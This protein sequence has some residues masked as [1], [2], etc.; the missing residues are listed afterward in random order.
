MSQGWAKRFYNSPAWLRNR[1]SYLNS[2]VDTSGH[3][4]NMSS[5][6]T[7]YYTD[8]YGIQV[9]VPSTSV[10]PPGMCER[11]FERGELVPA[12]VVHHIRHLTPENI[13][14]P[15]VT[16]AYDNFRRLCQDCHAFVHGGHDEPR[17]TFDESG[18][19]VPKGESL[20]DMVMRLT[21]TVDDRRNIH[22][23]SNGRE[24]R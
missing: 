7:Y 20:R 8:E 10:V 21:E 13:S 2:T 22:R 6:G 19:I 11:C 18:N 12:K 16:L 5:D 17:V 23:G 4:L 9:S 3:V 24:M 15:H 14:D 1:K